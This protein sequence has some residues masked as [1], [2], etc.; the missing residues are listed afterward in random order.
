[1][2]PK[3]AAIRRLIDAIGKTIDLEVDGGI[4]VENVRRIADAGADTFVAGSAIY[5][6]ANYVETIAKFRAAL[7]GAGR[8]QRSL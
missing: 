3:I 7:S 2:L 5:S 1:V 4:K 8:D 6:T